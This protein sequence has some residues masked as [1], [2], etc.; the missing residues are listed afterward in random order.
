MPHCLILLS[1]LILTHARHLYCKE[2]MYSIYFLPGLSSAHGKGLLI[3]FSYCIYHLVSLLTA[4]IRLERSKQYF[5]STT[6]VKIHYN[7]TLRSFLSWFSTSMTYLPEVTIFEP[8]RITHSFLNTACGPRHLRLDLGSSLCLKFFSS[9]LI[10]TFS[11]VPN[12]YHLFNKVFLNLLS[13][14]FFSFYF[15]YSTLQLKLQERFFHVLYL[16]DLSQWTKRACNHFNTGT[17]SSSQFS[18]RTQLSS[19]A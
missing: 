12:Q 11:Q 4:K 18:S 3:I 14:K 15:F 10:T 9:C 13:R 8:Q 5:A 6:M 1:N 7:L 2:F 19:T 16:L 17:I